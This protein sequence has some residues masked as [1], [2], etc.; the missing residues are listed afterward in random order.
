MSDT[1][2]PRLPVNAQNLLGSIARVLGRILR[3]RIFWFLLVPVMLLYC[4]ADWCTAYVPPNMVAIKQVFYGSNRG[5][6]SIDCA[7]RV[8]R[9]EQDVGARQHRE[10]AR[11]VERLEPDEI[12][13][14]HQGEEQRAL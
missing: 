8:R 9:L 12:G 3:T 7:S 4:G 6:D 14:V 5:N 11:T 13:E 10:Q 1:I 2:R